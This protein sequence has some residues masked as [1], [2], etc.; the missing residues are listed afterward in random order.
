MGTD[1]QPLTGSSLFT[2]AKPST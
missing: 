1:G 2:N